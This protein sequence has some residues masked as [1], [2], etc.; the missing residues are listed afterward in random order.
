MKVLPLR[1]YTNAVILDILARLFKKSG[2]LLESIKRLLQYNRIRL[3]ACSR[4]SVHK[5]GP[6]VRQEVSLRN[7]CKSAGEYPP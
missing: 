3:V 5:Q 2:T 1:T 7:H 4:D 6:F